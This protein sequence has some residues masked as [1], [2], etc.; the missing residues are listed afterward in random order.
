MYYDRKG[1]PIDV[2]TF[3][4]LHNDKDYVQVVRTL[5]PPTAKHS[6]STLSTVWLGIDHSFALN[7]T[8]PVIFE[9]MRF[10]A[11]DTIEFPCAG[12]EVTDQARYCTEQEAIEGHNRILRSIREIEG[13]LQ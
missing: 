3:A 5:V 10:A 11:H 6:W 4:K 7:P 1:N 2:W 8:L 12:G 13:Y 9:T